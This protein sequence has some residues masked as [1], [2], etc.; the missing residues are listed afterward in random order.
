VQNPKDSTILIVDDEPALRKAIVFDFKRKGFHVL[1]AENGTQAF[2]IVKSTKIDVVLTD[3]RMP[4]G[5]GTQLLEKIKNLCPDLPV[6]MF[7]TGFADISLE[8]AY[9]K[10]V[11]AV[12]AKPFDRKALFNSVLRA[13]TTKDEQWAFRHAERVDSEFNID[14]N[15][16][17]LHLALHGRVL[18]IGRGGMFVALSENLPQIEAKGSFNI[19]FNQGTPSY[20]DGTGIVRWIRTQERDGRPAGCGIEFESLNDESRRQIIDLINSLKTKSFIPRS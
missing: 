2:E 8:E 4:G 12:F 18:N 3:V 13:L 14:L 11:D 6:V 1:E 19:R 10:G 16:P 9:D 20:V 15:F 17:D 5:D 7:I